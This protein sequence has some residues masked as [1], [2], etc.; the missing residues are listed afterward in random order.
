MRPEAR[1]FRSDSYH[2]VRYRA[3]GLAA[4]LSAMCENVPLPDEPWVWSVFGGTCTMSP[5]ASLWLDV[6]R[7]PNPRPRPGRRL[8]VSKLPLPPV[9]ISIWLEP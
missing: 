3:P 1:D 4:T 7:I 9:A 2:H 6:R 8:Y 5:F